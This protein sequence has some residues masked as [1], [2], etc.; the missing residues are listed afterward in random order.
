M[1]H[2]LRRRARIVGEEYGSGPRDDD[3][4]GTEPGAVTVVEHHPRLA[5]HHRHQESG[6]SSWT[7]TDHGG[8][9]I[10]RSTKALLALGPSSRP[11]SASIAAA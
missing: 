11:T 6:A 8:F 5:A 7:R 2:D 3:V 4:A 1:D 10:E 9:M